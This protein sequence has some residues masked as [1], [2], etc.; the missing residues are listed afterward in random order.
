M[1]PFLTTHIHPTQSAFIN[2][3][4]ITN[5]V[6]RV[7]DVITKRKTGWLLFVDFLKA[8]DSVNRTALIK[9]MKAYRFHPSVVSY[10]SM[11]LRP[12]QITSRIFDLSLTVERGVPQGWS[13]S[14][15][16]FNLVIDPLLLHLQIHH[17]WLFKSAFADDM[18]DIFHLLKA[19]KTP[20]VAP[21]IG[22]ELLLEKLS[23]LST[24][25]I[26]AVHN[27]TLLSI[28]NYRFSHF[29]T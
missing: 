18:D 14:C 17:P 6:R 26:E 2:D 19:N 9:V 22:E 29:M 28:V 15:V 10:V 21:E 24:P 12:Y 11:A 3:R 4:W 7:N 23:K 25:S 16:L 27:I 13:L 5:N 8:Y 1:Q 20:K